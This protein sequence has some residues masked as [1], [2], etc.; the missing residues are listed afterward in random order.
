MLYSSLAA[1]VAFESGLPHA[2]E[3]EA[4]ELKKG[5]AGARTA[6]AVDAAAAEDTNNADALAR[7]LIGRAMLD[8]EMPDRAA[9]GIVA[10][11]ASGGPVAA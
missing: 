3:D 10:P 2:S 5:L 11:D 7:A 1:C 4:A 6:A 8:R 9:C